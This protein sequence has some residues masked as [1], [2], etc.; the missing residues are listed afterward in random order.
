MRCRFAR[1]PAE[2]R[3]EVMSIVRCHIHCSFPITRM[4]IQNF[5]EQASLFMISL[6]H[7]TN[8]NSCMHI[9]GHSIVFTSVYLARSMKHIIFVH[10]FFMTFRCKSNKSIAMFSWW[11]FMG[12]FIARYGWSVKH[13][14]RISCLKLC[15]LT[16]YVCVFILVSKTDFDE[17]V[18]IISKHLRLLF[19]F[20]ISNKLIC[21]GQ[22]CKV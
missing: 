15:T 6:A 5:F 14:T 19:A 9:F 11:R 1:N 16:F 13:Y 4:N 20:L 7:R 18:V 3:C 2:T 22:N 8:N 10:I 17:K 21:S 12:N